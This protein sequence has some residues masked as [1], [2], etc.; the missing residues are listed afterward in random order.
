VHGIRI[1]DCRQTLRY[2]EDGNIVFIA[3]SLGI[4][5]DREEQKERI[6]TG[7]THALISLDVD[8][9]GKIAATGELHANPGLHIWD[10]RTAKHILTM[11]NIHRTGIS[12]LAF[13]AS[14]EYLASLGQDSC[15]SLV[16][17]RSPS[18]RWCDGFVAYSCA[19]SHAKM[20]W[21]MLIE[22]NEYPVVVGGKGCMYFFRQS[23]KSAER[24]KGTFGKRKKLQPLLCGVEGAATENGFGQT[25]VLTGTVTGHLYLWLDRK[26]IGSVTAHESPIYVVTKLSQGYATG[27]KDGLVKI[28]NSELQLQHTY[29]S[30][31]F[32]PQ[33]MNFSVH[34]LK[35]NFSQTRLLVGM[36]S[37]ESAFQL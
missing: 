10:A 26:V 27:G 34:A 31:V 37:G 18:K 1:G 28:W 23:G 32:E 22:S 15:H 21:V 17:M 12:S 3:S 4:V 9:S 33:P 16:V 30:A 25:T 35:A 36:R 7:H 5:F 29:N 14:S 20:F 6:Y 13:S 2:N 19:V 24:C 11:T 8:P